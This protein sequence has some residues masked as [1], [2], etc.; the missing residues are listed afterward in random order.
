MISKEII[1]PFG[2]V[3]EPFV[4]DNCFIPIDPVLMAREGWGNNIDMIFGGCSGE[5]Q[6]SLFSLRADENFYKKESI[7]RYLATDLEL[8][9]GDRKRKIYGDQ[10]VKLYYGAEQI[11]V[12]NLDGY[13]K[14]NFS[15]N[16]SFILPY[17]FSVPR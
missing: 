4:S 16:F 1:E 13:V 14:V 11:S 12:D 15:F 2:S 9:V 7:E 10:M 17:I 3:V 8:A 5:G 6:L